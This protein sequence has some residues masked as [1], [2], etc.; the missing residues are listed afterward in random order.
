MMLDVFSSLLLVGIERL[1]IKE[2]DMAERFA[3]TGY[4]S[5]SVARQLKAQQPGPIEVS[6]ERGYSDVMM[7]MDGADI[8]EVRI[9]ASAQGE[10]LVQLLLR[11]SAPVETVI[12]TTADAN[13]ISRFYD[14]ILTRLTASASIKVIYA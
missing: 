8:T 10:T 9:G 5:D 11:D 12:R 1:T 7:R 14:P 3:V 13:G 2:I 6:P 4:V